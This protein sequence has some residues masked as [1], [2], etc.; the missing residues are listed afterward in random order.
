M[1]LSCSENDCFFEQ[2]LGT[3]IR[4]TS[5]RQTTAFLYFPAP[6]GRKVKMG[7]RTL[8]ENGSNDFTHFAYLDRL[9]QYLQLLY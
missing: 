2:I 8:L 9:D 3:H 1:M 6:S 7:F 4:Q 5:D